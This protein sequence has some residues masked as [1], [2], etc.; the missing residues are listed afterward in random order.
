MN[1]KY[2]LFFYFILYTIVFP[3][4]SSKKNRYSKKIHTIKT[5]NK[6]GS[7][8]NEEVKKI[9]LYPN[10]P[11]FEN[12]NYSKMYFDE[13]NKKNNKSLDDKID[14]E[15]IDQSH[16]KWRVHKGVVANHG[17][18]PA[19][20][21]NRNGNIESYTG[22][23]YIK[24]VN[25]KG[26]FVKWNTGLNYS[27]G[28]VDIGEYDAYSIS[29]GPGVGIEKSYKGFDL[30]SG[31]DMNLHYLPKLDYTSNSSSN[32]YS[33]KDGETTMVKVTPNLKL[34]RKFYFNRFNISTYGKASI[35]FNDYLNGSEPEV[36]IENPDISQGTLDNGF[37][38]KGGVDLEYSDTTLGV[39]LN[40]FTGKYNS[41]K[42]MGSVKASYTF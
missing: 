7:F 31:I 12:M 13:R 11:R 29:S 2:F 30:S 39:E 18:S 16:E 14:Y 27:T 20:Y 5:K 36:E 15:I 17:K 21:K 24:A 28:N 8:K 22:N 6:Y 37:H 9:E 33:S 38:L 42:T 35:N 25:D 23:A 1:L 3:A 4:T 26:Y 32:S 19:K 41:D 40:H 10:E 34:N